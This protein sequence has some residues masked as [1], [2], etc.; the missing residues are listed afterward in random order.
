MPAAECD[1]PAVAGNGRPQSSLSDQPVRGG[2]SRAA[3][4]N[5]RSASSSGAAPMAVAEEEIMI[6][7][8]AKIAAP[9]M[10]VIEEQQVFA[11]P[12][13]APLP[14]AAPASVSSAA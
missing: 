2:G 14:V 10:Q 3:A 11:P 4:L 9:V 7:G 8:A 13:F 12:S 5:A 6:A 1:A